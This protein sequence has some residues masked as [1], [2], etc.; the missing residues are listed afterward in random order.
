VSDVRRQS[1]SPKRRGFTLI[2]ALMASV[3]FLLGMAGTMPLMFWGVKFA[4]GAHDLNTAV[5]TVHLVVDRLQTARALDLE[6]AGLGG[7]PRTVIAAPESGSTCFFLSTEDRQAPQPEDCMEV[8]DNPLVSRAE[9][10][11]KFQVAWTLEQ[12]RALAGAPTIDRIL[13]EVAWRSS[14]D[15]VHRVKSNARVVR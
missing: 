11:R 8:G 5:E 2:E 4:R 3:V 1:R 14:D 12:E 15:R 10:D 7:S 13:V 9:V 6:M